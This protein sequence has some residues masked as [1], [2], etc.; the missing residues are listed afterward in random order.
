MSILPVDPIN[1]SIYDLSGLHLL[2][3]P[4][5][6]HSLKRKRAASAPSLERGTSPGEQALTSFKVGVSHPGNVP[7][8][9]KWSAVEVL[10]RGHSE[11]P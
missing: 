10:R 3:A 6:L 4:G 2:A 11:H 8:L 5:T 9:A 1:L 7:I